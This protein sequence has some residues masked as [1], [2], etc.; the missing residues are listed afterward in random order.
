[1]PN[2]QEVGAVSAQ[3]DGIRHRVQ[4][5]LC[6]IVATRDA[7]FGMMRMFEVLAG[8]Y[9]RATRVFRA[10]D[11]AEEWLLAQQGGVNPEK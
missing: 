4:F 7:L 8:D 11:R 6:A 1:L 5:G 10:M 9:F 3:L 2:S